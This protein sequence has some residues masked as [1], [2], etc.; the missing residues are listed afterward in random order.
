MG[1]NERRVGWVIVL[2][3][4]R[5]RVELRTLAVQWGVAAYFGCSPLPDR[6]QGFTVSNGISVSKFLAGNL[7]I[8]AHWTHLCRGTTDSR[9][10]GIRHCS[11]GAAFSF[12]VVC[13]S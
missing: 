11:T 6:A 13:S 7:Q 10:D 4:R 1:N 2:D 9:H 8:D 3:S 5:K 12:S